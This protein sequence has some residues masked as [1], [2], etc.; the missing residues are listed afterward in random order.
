MLISS[1][2]IRWFV[3]YHGGSSF[4][5]LDA[6][7]TSSYACEM[8]SV[9]VPMPFCRVVV[10]RT[11]SARILVDRDTNEWREIGRGVVFYLCFLS[12]SAVED[13]SKVD[14][15]VD[16]LLRAKLVTRGD[17]S[18]PG[19]GLGGV[20]SILESSADVAVIPQASLSSKLKGK[21]VQFHNA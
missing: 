12:G 4:Y 5:V 1:A 20:M 2:S 13:V 16:Q 18:G 21:V 3:N 10:Q 8:S 6:S 14:R 7:H 15:V 19:S 17:D 9:P 11:K